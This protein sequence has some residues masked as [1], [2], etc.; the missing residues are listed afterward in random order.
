MANRV[1]PEQMPC[2][3]AYALGLHM[4]TLLVQH[5]GSAYTCIFRGHLTLP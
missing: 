5:Q 2:S 3:A 1:E 4:N